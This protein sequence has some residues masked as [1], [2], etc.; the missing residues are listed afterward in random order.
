MSLLTQIRSRFLPRRLAAATAVR[1]AR[2]EV[3]P[4]D[5]LPVY[6]LY[7]FGGPSSEQPAVK[8]RLAQVRDEFLDMLDDVPERADLS[9]RIARARSLRELWHLR[10]DVFSLVSLRFSQHEAQSRL[11]R[12]NRHF[13][14]RALGSGFAPL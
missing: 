5:V 3:C 7:G 1:P 4:P 13:P 2:I 10:A 8:D 6:A 9:H 12:L 14:T 11:S